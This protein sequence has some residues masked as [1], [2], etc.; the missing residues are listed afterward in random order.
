MQDK[1]TLDG[2]KLL[3]QRGTLLFVSVIGFCVLLLCLCDFETLEDVS[4]CMEYE[5]QGNTAWMK[6]ALAAGNPPLCLCDW[7][8]FF[9]FVFW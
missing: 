2:G 6:I 4:K 5:R 7:I 3:W 1:G 8:L 9:V